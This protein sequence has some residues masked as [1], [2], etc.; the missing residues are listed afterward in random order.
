MQL[1]SGGHS[2]QLRGWTY[3][4]L[5][6]HI[7]G[8]RIACI[9]KDNLVQR[10]CDS[11]CSCASLQLLERV[12]EI[13]PWVR[14][15]G[16]SSEYDKSCDG[17]EEECYDFDNANDIADPVREPGVRRYNYSNAVLECVKRR[18]GLCWDEGYL[19]MKATV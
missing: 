18:L 19:L 17:D 13:R 11:I 1:E 7:E 12:S 2:S 16:V 4:D 6:D 14:N 5:V 15:P 3:L 9:C 10:V 8:V